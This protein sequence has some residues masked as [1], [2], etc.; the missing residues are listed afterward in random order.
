MAKN[1]DLRSMLVVARNFY[2]GLD[3]FDNDK[4]KAYEWYKSA[5]DNGHRQATAWVGKMLLEGDGTEQKI[6]E[7]MMLVSYAAV[8]GSKFAT[9][10]IGM[11]YAEGKHGMPKNADEAKHW[12]QKSLSNTGHCFQKLNQDEENTVGRT[13]AKLSYP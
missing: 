9:F 12:L 2:M 13:L 6:K 5:H 4:K 1:C 7:G 8:T 10:I 3:G 11:A